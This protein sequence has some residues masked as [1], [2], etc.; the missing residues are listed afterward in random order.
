MALQNG[1][2]GKTCSLYC[3]KKIFFVACKT[4]NRKILTTAK[5]TRNG[6]QTQKKKR[7]NSFQAFL[8][9]QN[10]IFFWFFLLLKVFSWQALS[11]ILS[12]RSYK[13]VTLRKTIFYRYFQGFSQILFQFHCIS[14]QYSK[15]FSVVT[16]KE[17]HLVVNVPIL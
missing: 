13:E 8:N 2:Y 16:F 9:A 6:T 4:D 17:L 7:K 5:F 14:S 10:M 11:W 3:T 12:S 15:V 1:I